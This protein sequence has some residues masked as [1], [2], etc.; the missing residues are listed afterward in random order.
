MKEWHNSVYCCLNKIAC[1]FKES[2]RAHQAGEKCGLEGYQR[3][4]SQLRKNKFWPNLP[5]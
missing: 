5:I 1:G 2:A 4:V 3:I